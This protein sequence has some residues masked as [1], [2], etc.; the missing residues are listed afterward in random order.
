MKRII[1]LVAVLVVAAVT[2]GGAGA[3]SARTDASNTDI[4]QTAVAAGQF[5]TL[6]SLLQ[7]AGLVDT[8]S[9]GGPF[10]VFAPTDAAFAKVPKATL[11]ALAADPAKLKA[12]LLYHVVPG[13]VTA[14]DVVKLTSAK[15]AEGQ[16]L[17]IK[18]TNGSV[19]V[20]GAQVTTPD[21]EASNGVIHVIDSVLIPQQMTT[22]TPK[23]IVQTA[24]AAGSFKTLTSLLKKAGLVG[25]LQG[26]GPF[27]V[28][29]PTD[30]AF[31]KVPK[32]TLAALAKNK[33]KLR[34]VLLYHV[35]KGNVPAAKVVKLR[36]AKTLNGKAVSIRVTGKNVS[37]GGARVTTPD[38]KASNGVIHVINKVL[39]P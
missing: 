17:A 37:V 6:A 11:D 7:Q 13:R 16:S 28:F 33:A 9:T 1:S 22:T 21:V 8:L 12:V 38:V 36:S 4:V 10:T 30:A 23:T 14:A 24:V 39:I 25:A 31:A 29:A 5:T 27:T 35:V 18:V 15:T 26:K 3:A 34:K 32:A 2:V 20:D 19:F